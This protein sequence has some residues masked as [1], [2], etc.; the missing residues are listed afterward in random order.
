M[1]SRRRWTDPAK[2]L[3]FLALLG[4]SAVYA[5]DGAQA[6]FKLVEPS[7]VTVV[8]FD[9]KGNEDGQ[10]SGVVVTGERVA[11]NCHVVRDA[12]V[13]KVRARSGEHGAEWTV[14]DPS[15]DLCFLSAPGLRAPPARIRPHAEI[16]VGERVFAV[17]NPLGFGLSVSEGLISTIAPVGGE[18]IILT[19]AALS[20]GSSGGG[21]FDDQGR[22]VGITTGIMGAGQNLNIALPAEWIGELESRGV[23]GSPPSAVPEPEPRWLSEAEELRVRMAWPALEVLAR[24]WEAVHPGS[25]RAAQSLGLALFNMGNKTDAERVLREA[26]SRDNRDAGAWSY[27]ALVLY[28]SGKKDE[29]EKAAE[30]A[31]ALDPSQSYVLSLR[32]SWLRESGQFDAALGMI[33]RAILIEPWQSGLWIELGET[34]MERKHWDEAARAFRVALRLDPGNALVKNR[35]ASVLSRG[36]QVDKARVVLATGDSVSTANSW[37][38]VSVGNIAANRLTDAESAVRKAIAV[39]PGNFLAW[40][41]LGVVLRRTGRE[42]EAEDAF[43]RALTLKP[44]FAPSLVFRSEISYGRGN[45]QGAIEALRQA[46]AADPLNAETWRT[47]A[48]V[49]VEKRDFSEAAKA[50]RKIAELGKASVADLAGLSE[51]L[52]RTGQLEQAAEV[53][54]QAESR[55]PNDVG[56]L[57]GYAA[58]WGQKGQHELAFDFATRAANAEPGNANA[59]SSK[60]Y[61]AIL[62][63]NFKE[64]I[65]ALEVA[66]GI[67]PSSANALINLGHA[68]LRNN[69][70]GKAIQTIEKALKL[71]PEAADAHLYLAQAYLGIRQNAKAREEA[72]LALKHAPN[73]PPAL[74]VLTLSLLQEGRREES[75]AAYQRLKARN[76]VAARALRTQA[77]SR[78][79]AGAVLLPD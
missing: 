50:Y 5:D 25:S 4:V 33:N 41:T 31:S 19:S 54:R 37:I 34:E 8:T 28:H 75:V 74:A 23:P 45:I 47:L 11:T 56:V 58:L 62:T 3:L 30:R 10:G 26:V 72:E 67:D 40:H 77:I 15:R 32:A 53:L 68:Y 57:L 24:Q 20:P 76:P 66:V 42:K 44:G 63:G 7:I 60:G 13:M 21:L 2:S 14:A 36:G 27:L 43:E 78:G 65:A 6:V 49:L 9:E 12:R 64:A 38:E 29:A 18:P 70:A 79:I 35:L 39:E 69:E 46:V 61:A 73:L 48:R 52:R 51:C 55:A 22:L 71:A 16:S 1:N 17:G 59:W